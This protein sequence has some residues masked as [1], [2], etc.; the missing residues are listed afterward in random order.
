MASK[1]ARLVRS[2]RRKS[3]PAHKRSGDTAEQIAAVARRI[4]EKEGA[5]AVSMH[6]IARELGVT[7]MA[8]YHHYE[9]RDAL[10]RH[11]INEE[12]LQLVAIG[13][14]LA[15]DPA[16]PKSREAMMDAYF[17]YALERP[18]MFD[19]LFNQ[20]RDENRSRY[21]TNFRNRESPSLT[22]VADRIEAMMQSGELRKDDVWEVTMQLWAH[23]HGFVTMYR[24][25]LFDMSEDEFRAFY[26][27]AMKRLF[28]GFAAEP[29]KKAKRS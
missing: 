7:P 18:H 10:L 4:L 24:N 25:G 1:E 6:R 5:G 2:D 3:A 12:L 27:R 22:P 9:N 26:H 15:A 28:E 14:R 16:A 17:Y 11:L 13:D 23:A 21:P 8:I 29:S 20:A 19:Y